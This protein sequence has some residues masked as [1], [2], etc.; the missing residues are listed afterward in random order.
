MSTALLTDS[1]AT[2]V[3]PGMVALS[4]FWVSVGLARWWKGRQFLDALLVLVAA[5]LLWDGGWHGSRWVKQTVRVDI[6]NAGCK[7]GF[8][9]RAGQDVEVPIFPLLGIL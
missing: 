8:R 2:I 9:P 5:G 4:L 6:D 7:A 1:I 3:Y